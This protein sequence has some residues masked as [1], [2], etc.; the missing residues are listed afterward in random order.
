MRNWRELH[1]IW[2][3]FNNKLWKNLTCPVKN[4]QKL[5]TQDPQLQNALLLWLDKSIFS[6][7]PVMAILKDHLVVKRISFQGFKGHRF[8][9]GAAQLAVSHGMLEEH[10]QKIE[11]LVFIALKLYC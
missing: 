2:D 7:K 9:E 8:R 1:K 6:R 10:I 4:L 11:K 5:F 3:Y